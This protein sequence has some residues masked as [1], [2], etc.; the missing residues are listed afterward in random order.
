MA[1]GW[2][3]STPLP[4][5][6]TKACSR[7]LTFTSQNVSHCSLQPQKRLGNTVLVRNKVLHCGSA[8]VMVVLLTQSLPHSL[9]ALL[10]VLHLSLALTTPDSVTH[11]LTPCG[12]P[13]FLTSTLQ[14]C[15]EAGPVSS[16]PL[17]LPPCC[18]PTSLPLSPGQLSRASSSPHLPAP[19]PF[20]QL[21]LSFLFTLPPL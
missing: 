11:T 10:S 7:P 6:V 14:P 16:L 8:R 5:E 1:K 17:L 3:G 9:L 19:L 18:L 4:R 13:T 15:K 2:K 20:S 12:I 21:W